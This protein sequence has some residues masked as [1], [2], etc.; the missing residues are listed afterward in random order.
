M[1][2][3]ADIF[4]KIISI[5]NLFSAWD[6][7]YKDKKQK[8]DV[9]HFEFELEQHI[10]QLHRDLKSKKYKHG[11]YTDFYIQDPKQRHIHKA[12][13]RDRVLH[14]A[15]FKILNPI[16]EP[17]FISNSFSCRVGYGT[18]KGVKVL[19]GILRKISKNG[20]A[21]CFGLKC[22]IQKFFDSVDH[23]IL[24][25]ILK[26]RIKDSNVLWLLNEIIES[27]VSKPRERERERE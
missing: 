21:P 10:F 2:S 12:L 26:R 14:H 24:F 25:A 20:T 16:F 11:P 8:E 9:Q 19:E 6:E 15:V 23:V 27:Y 7:F 22:D 4:D 13:V 3:Y 1:K 18:H 17:T 5:E